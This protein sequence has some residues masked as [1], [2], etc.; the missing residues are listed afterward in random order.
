M[1]SSNT[2]NTHRRRPRLHRPDLLRRRPRVAL[3]LLES[4]PF[5][6][7][8][9]HLATR[10]IDDD[11]GADDASYFDYDGCGDDVDGGEGVYGALGTV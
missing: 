9:C 6:V 2:S 5:A 3:F 4:L 10:W 1:G 8:A 7:S 11:S